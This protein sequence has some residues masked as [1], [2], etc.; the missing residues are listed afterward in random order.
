MGFLAKT[1]FFFSFSSLIITSFVNNLLSFF[2]F[3]FFLFFLKI[4]YVYS[5]CLFFFISSNQ[6]F[7]SS[8]SQKRIK[9]MFHFNAI[10]SYL[11]WI[12]GWW[13][14]SELEWNLSD[15]IRIAVLWHAL[16]GPSLSSPP[17]LMGGWTLNPFLMNIICSL[18]QQHS[19]SYKKR[20]KTLRRGI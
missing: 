6:S 14:N 2:S 8:S 19:P 4:S 20:R 18:A 13:G 7:N 17:P 1:K 9:K 5:C 16:L 3:L 15:E 11:L 12:C 10:F